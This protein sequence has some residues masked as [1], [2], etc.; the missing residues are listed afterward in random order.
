MEKVLNRG[1]NFAILPLKLNITQVLV[2]FAKFER[3]MLWHKFWAD[4]PKQD[5]KSPI[6]KK[7]KTNLPKNHPTPAGLKTFLNGAKSEIE[8]PENRIKVRPNLPPD[9]LEG[10]RDLI[11]LQKERKITIKPCQ[12]QN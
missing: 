1:L 3:T 10:L 4:S 12:N 5:Y 8:D 11:K 6:S 9:E 2:D 7:E